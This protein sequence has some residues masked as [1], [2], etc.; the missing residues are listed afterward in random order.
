[1]Y[2]LLSSMEG[3]NVLFDGLD[4]TGKTTLI[5]ALAEQ[6]TTEGYN[7]RV[8]CEPTKIIP[9]SFPEYYHRFHT[10]YGLKIRSLQ[11]KSLTE[12]VDENET[13]FE[14]MINLFVNDR[15]LLLPEEKGLNYNGFNTFK[16]RGFTSMPF[17]IAKGVLEGVG[18]IRDVFEIV[19]NANKKIIENPEYQPD[20][21]VLMFARDEVRETRAR[22]SGKGTDFFEQK[23]IAQIAGTVYDVL[24]D[25]ILLKCP[26]FRSTFYY[27]DT[28]DYAIPDSVSVAR[29]FLDPLMVKKL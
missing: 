3:L 1:M 13:C 26:E 21:V 9:D 24:E 6:Y 23:N 25:L 22:E 12:C 14:R 19:Y 11:K 17:Q 28:S 8:L 20:A 18:E 27:I 7:L 5:K 4:N 16:D 2:K 29:E 15:L 10:E